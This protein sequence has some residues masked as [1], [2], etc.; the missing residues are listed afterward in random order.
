LSEELTELLLAT[1]SVVGEGIF[2]FAS[3]IDFSRPAF[4]PCEI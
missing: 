3:S 2:F 1:F 4:L